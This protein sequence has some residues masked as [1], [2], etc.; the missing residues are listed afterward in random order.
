MVHHE[1]HFVETRIVACVVVIGSATCIV[2]FREIYFSLPV[3]FAGWD[4][5]IKERKLIICLLFHHQNFANENGSGGQ[6]GQI[7]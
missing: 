2:S 5:W 1:P 6:E 4:S 7:A 3:E